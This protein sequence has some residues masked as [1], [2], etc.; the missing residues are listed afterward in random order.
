MRFGYQ[1]FTPEIMTAVIIVL[2]VLVQI[3][4][5]FGSRLARTAAKRV[6]HAARLASHATA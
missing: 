6:S 5:L 3:I 2:I 1:H 4:Q